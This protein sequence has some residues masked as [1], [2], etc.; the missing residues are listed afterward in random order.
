MFFVV[1]LLFFSC[2]KSNES[3]IKLLRTEATDYNGV[4]LTTEYGYDSEGR[5][6][7][8]KQAENSAPP[9][10]AFSI[11]YHGNEI[12]MLSYPQI[13][14]DYYTTKEVHLKL[15]AA[16]KLLNKTGY[17]RAVGI[18]PYNSS[19]KKFSYDTW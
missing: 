11:T 14:P 6:V 9:A 10:V 2:K 13:D 5:I 17:T 8:I 7:S 12:T 19:S 4:L 3:P 1:F 16:G 15:D 18:Q